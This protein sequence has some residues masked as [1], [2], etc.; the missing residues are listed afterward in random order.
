MAI[1]HQ[2]FTFT[3][4]ICCFLNILLFIS[5]T[6]LFPPILRRYDRSLGLVILGVSRK[7]L[8]IA[9]VLLS[10]KFVSSKLNLFSVIFWGQ[11]GLNAAIVITLTYWLAQ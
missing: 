4:L 6:Y 9:T 11:R 10:L 5:L 2:S 3:V 7:P 1:L 8:T